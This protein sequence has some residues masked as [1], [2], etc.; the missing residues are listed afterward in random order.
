GT[1]KLL[2]EHSL[3]VLEI[4]D[5]KDLWRAA[6]THPLWQCRDAE[7]DALIGSFGLDNI[8]APLRFID[9][10]ELERRPLRALAKLNRG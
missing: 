8:G 2:K 9:T 1:I 5:G 6:V 7:R 3:P 4:N 10:F